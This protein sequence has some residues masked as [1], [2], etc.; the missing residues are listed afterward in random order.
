MDSLEDAVKKEDG[1]LFTANRFYSVHVHVS[2][3][4][5]CL[6]NRSSQ[7]HVYIH[8]IFKLVLASVLNLQRKNNRV[9]CLSYAVGYYQ[10]NK[11]IHLHNV[12]LAKQNAVW[13][14]LCKK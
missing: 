14:K 3:M 11:Q 10:D 9:I 6:I 4:L 7:W 2:G 1:G 8:V 5:S 13:F 12:T